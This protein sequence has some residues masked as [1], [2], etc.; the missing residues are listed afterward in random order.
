MSVVY[1]LLNLPG[2]NREH[3]TQGRT[4]ALVCLSGSQSKRNRHEHNSDI[5]GEKGQG[6]RRWGG[7]VRAVGVCCAHKH[8]YLKTNLVNET[9]S[10]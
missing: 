8:N 7:R 9:V 10:C 4:E 5:C 3:Q 6:G 2:Y 1:P